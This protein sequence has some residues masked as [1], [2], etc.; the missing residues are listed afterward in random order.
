[1]NL[2]VIHRTGHLRSRVYSLGVEFD[3]H[4][5]SVFFRLYAV[6]SYS[7]AQSIKNGVT[8]ELFCE[9]KVTTIEPV[10]FEIDRYFCGV[11]QGW[12]KNQDACFAPS[13]RVLNE[14]FECSSM[15]AYGV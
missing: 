7:T 8:Y 2:R 1:M 11:V 13:C 14:E 10:E 5:P 9:S 12:L 6:K 4:P 3:N 15:I